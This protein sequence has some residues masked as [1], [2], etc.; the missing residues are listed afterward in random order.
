MVA[1][2]LAVHGLGTEGWRHATAWTARLS[3]L[4]FVLAFAARPLAQLTR[5][6]RPLL[7]ERR[8][9]GLA[10]A[11]A[12]AIHGVAIVV[13]FALRSEWPATVTLIGGGSAYVVIAA[14]SLTS[15]DGAQH[16]MGRNWR[17]LHLA[18]MMFL[19]L[20]FTNSYVGRLFDPVSFPVGLYGTT[21]LMTAMAIRLAAP[22]AR[23]ARSA[24]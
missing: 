7:Y 6:A 5:V 10:F 11:A 13:Y 22:L 21:L 18:G 16:R 20:I 12:H 14:M 8:G 15:T 24:G 2:G 4:P 9:L 19:W 17:R 1:A 3:L 23:R